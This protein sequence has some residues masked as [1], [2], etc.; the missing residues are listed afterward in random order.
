MAAFRAAGGR[1]LNV[2]VPFKLKPS[3]WPIAT[4][5]PP[6]PA[7]WNTLAFGPDG[8]LGD[9]T[10]GAGI[11]RDITV[12]LR[13][14]VAGKRVLLLGAGGA[15]QGTVL[16]LLEARPAS[17]VIA[18]RT[19][20][21]AADLADEFTSAGAIRPEGCGFIQPRRPTLRHRHQRHQ[22]QPVRRRPRPARRPLRAG[23]PGLR[24]DVRQGRHSVHGRRPPARRRL[25]ADG[26]GMLVEQAAELPALAWRAPRHGAGARRT[27]RRPLSLRQ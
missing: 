2:T 8:I 11:L 19:A 6:Q 14:P 22:C 9:N 3:T 5:A 18:N 17:L 24:H 27:A 12:N 4:R 1:G 20:A 13:C 10:D 16:P 26:L 25:V 15:A 23:Q 21:R 7:S